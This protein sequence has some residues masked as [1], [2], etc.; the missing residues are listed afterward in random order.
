MIDIEVDNNSHICT[1]KGY[2]PT[3]QTDREYK[4]S[5]IYYL[6]LSQE[7]AA[8][9]AKCHNLDA[10]SI[11]KDGYSWVILFSN[12]E[13]YKYIK[14]PEEWVLKSYIVKERNPVLSRRIV[15]CYDKNGDKVFE[16]DNL[17]SIIKQQDGEKKL[18][19]ASDFVGEKIGYNNN[20]SDIGQFDRIRHFKIDNPDWV[21]KKHVSKIDV[22]VNKHAN[23]IAYVRWGLESLP[24]DEFDEDKLKKLR[25][26]WSRE[27]MIN[28]DI[29]IS[30]QKEVL[31]DYKVFNINMSDRAYMDIFLSM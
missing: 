23:N 21:V 13:V 25:V 12:L 16:T 2:I 20:V 31:Q 27:V 6:S 30:I 26:N 5:V 22:D 3:F 9:H 28:E 18:V 29:E 17:W 7:I 11:M 8:Y 14:W 19:S 15:E 24:C 10:P 4:A 1:M